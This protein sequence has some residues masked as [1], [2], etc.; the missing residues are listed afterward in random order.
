VDRRHRQY[1]GR[2]SLQQTLAQVRGAVGRSGRNEDYV[3]STA[4][5]LTEAGVADPRLHTLAAQLRQLE[6]EE[7]A[8]TVYGSP[9]GKS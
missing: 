3:L 9:S 7:E 2:L 4:D 1:A 6:A 8:A 5:H